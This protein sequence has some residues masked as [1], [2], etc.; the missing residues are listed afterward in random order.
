MVY[1]Q[2]NTHRYIKGFVTLNYLGEI[3]SK[4]Y[5][6]KNKKDLIFL[7]LKTM[8]KKIYGVSF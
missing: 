2:M 3:V 6:K 1:I 7:I 4:E 5:T 8:N